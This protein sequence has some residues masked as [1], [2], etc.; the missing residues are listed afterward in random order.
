MRSA[1]IELRL[2]SEELA[3]LEALAVQRGQTRSEVL[4]AVLQPRE[5]AGRMELDEAL[6][7]LAGHARAGSKDAAMLLVR[8]L[9]RSAPREPEPEREPD[10][11]ERLLGVAPVTPLRAPRGAQRSK[12]KAG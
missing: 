10:E 1:R 11:L 9:Q 7:L 8:S 5:A 6:E 3:R 4:R 2:S 12:R